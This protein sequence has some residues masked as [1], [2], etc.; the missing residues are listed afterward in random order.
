ML[1]VMYHSRIDA[2]H[3]EQCTW[4]GHGCYFGY[5]HHPPSYVASL[6]VSLMEHSCLPAN[7]VRASDLM[8]VLQ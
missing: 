5:D 8:D 1:M 6:H 4:T 2:L 7:V 3:S